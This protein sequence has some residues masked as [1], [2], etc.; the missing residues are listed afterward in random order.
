METLFIENNP[1][2]GQKVLNTLERELADCEAFYLSVAFITSG[3]ITPLLEVLKTLNQRKIKGQIITSDYLL[4]SEPKALN[5]LETF[6]NIE[7][8]MYQSTKHQT[9]FHTK[10]Y[11]FQKADNYKLL[12]GSSNLTMKAITSNK[13]WNSLVYS[14]DNK[15]FTDE[16]IR[17]FKA[18]WDD[19]D[20]VAYQTI[21]DAY[22]KQYDEHMQI[23]TELLKR[24][25]K[26]SSPLFLPNSMQTAFINNFRT[27]LNNH[28]KRGLL[29]SATGTGKT[30]AA[31]FAVSAVNPLRLL[32]LVHREQIAQKAM[33]TFKTIIK[34]KTYGLLSGNHKEH[35][36]DYLFSTVQSMAKDDNL[37]YFKPEHFD[38]II[39]DEVHRSGADS[40]QK[41]MNYFKPKYYLGMTASPERSDD[42]D[43]FKLFDHNILYEIRL[44]KALEE[45]L[46][47][48]FHYFGISDL[49]L[50]DEKD[51]DLS[52]FNK[53]VDDKRVDYIMQYADYYGY[54]GKRVKGLIFVSRQDEARI[55]SAKF[56]ERGLK[57][58]AL[59]GNDSIDQREE[60]IK[61]LTSDSRLDYLDYLITVDIFN[62]GI[63]IPEI[64]QVI[65][66]RPTNS[67][68]V[69]V[70][71][72]G[73][74]LRKAKNKE[75][76][77]IIDFIAN[78]RNNFLIPIAL[79]GDRSFNKDN[80]RRYLQEEAK[81]L[82]GAST[83]HFDEIS[84]KRIYEA[85]D[86]ANF[87][88]VRL[89][90][91]AYQNLKFKL[92]RIPK[93]MDFDLYGSIDPLRIFDNKSL[94]SYYNFLKKYEK[95][96]N[97]N[98]NAKE[99]KYL[100]FVSRKFA[101]GKRPHE[102]CALHYLMNNDHG[103]FDYLQDELL[104]RYGFKLDA[105]TQDNLVNILTAEFQTGSSRETFKDCI[106]IVKEGQDYGIAHNF[107]KMLS[108]NNFKELLNE[109]IEF[110]LY[111][112]E[113]NY[114]HPYQNTA[115][116]LYQKYTYEDV[117]RLLNWEKAEVALN[118]GGYKFDKK[119]KTFPVFI[120]YNKD[121]DI[122]DTIKYEDTLLA[123]D[124][125]I[126]ISKSGRS[127]K[128]DDVQTVLNAK[129]LGIDIEL[130][131]RKN[132]DDAI[133]KEFYY[134]G[135]IHPSGKCKEFIMPNTDKKAVEIEYY[136]D[137]PINETLY[138]YI[139]N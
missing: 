100:E 78:Y 95:E 113:L 34:D 2:A 53:L 31:A 83:I 29:I 38:I 126:A 3:G 96:Y 82:P 28:D 91:E 101:D 19:V 24:L 9:G 45:D 65:M 112:N 36:T 87:N 66:L 68:I 73:R 90:K 92:G 137:T 81:T 120:N 75:Y 46:L 110:G 128:S 14:Q 123:K 43:I 129:S 33:S 122:A 85:I 118:I 11:I 18:L 111:R 80:L 130:F 49:Y 7:L 67:A 105:N 58:L 103:L 136:L 40:Y 44:A 121:R 77:V 56:N 64:N 94:G 133:S 93:L 131:I 57:T 62:E 60:A 74:G 37:A 70:Q 42:F 47:C 17:A 98:L 108:N 119:T 104:N 139:I 69:F 84:K 124:R 54:N 13:E 20:T 97:I 86:S 79:S 39:I 125:L 59:T 99:A 89:I 21:K 12:I 50:D 138:D 72:L 10:G 1:H 48:P 5:K 76:V 16:A 114:C 102:L 23:R 71:Q 41:I 51:D 127:L 55:L 109:V 61:R 115:F 117:C 25:D 63:D 8:R 30:F 35:H 132:K 134:M 4:F 22:A 106:F 52:H 88:D 15:A 116:N 107:K 32:F 27:S 135:K 6:D 26:Q